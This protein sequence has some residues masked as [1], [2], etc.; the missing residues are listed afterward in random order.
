MSQSVISDNWSLQNISEL[1]LDGMDDTESHYI[2]ADR[3]NDSYEY[4]SIP[5]AVIQTEALFDFITDIIL[6]DQIIVEEEFTNAWNH[7]GNPLDRAVDAGV[8]R[9]YPFL[10]DFEKLTEPTNE[11]VNRLCAT[12]ELKKDHE[13][14]R[15]GWAKNRQTPNRYLSQILWGGAGMLARGFVY[16]KGYTPHPVRKRLFIDAGI[17]LTSEDAVV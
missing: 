7:H 14:N 4:K 16:E 13:E 2:E 17:S 3:R 15:V 1:L 6:R 5:S 8:I 9:S 12:T 11:F 10:L